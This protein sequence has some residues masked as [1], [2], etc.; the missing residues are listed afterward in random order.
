MYILFVIFPY[1]Y[2]G[3]QSYATDFSLAELVVALILFRDTF[4]DIAWVYEKTYDNYKFVICDSS[5]SV[6]FRSR[7]WRHLD[8]PLH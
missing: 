1:K 3:G 2:Y 4:R 8:A 5:S 6:N 7:H